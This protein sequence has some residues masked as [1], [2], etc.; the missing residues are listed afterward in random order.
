MPLYT[1]DY[2]RDTRHL[3]PMRHGIYLLLLM[4]CWDQKGPLPLDANECG[5]IANCRSHDEIDALNYV[6]NKYFVKMDDGWYNHRMHDE[7]KK[8]ERESEIY[9]EAGLKSAEI[10]RAKSAKRR[11]DIA[12]RTKVEPRLNLGLTSVGNP[13]PN[14]NPIPNQ[15][16]VVLTSSASTQNSV[17]NQKQ[18]QILS[19][20]VKKTDSPRQRKTLAAISDDVGNTGT[21]GKRGSSRENNTS[22]AP[23]AAV[24]NSYAAA[25]EQRWHALPTRNAHVNGMLARFVTRV[26]AAEAPDIAAFYVGSPKTL[27]VNAKHAVNLLLRDAEQL[28]TEWL[29]GIHGTQTQ[30]RQID[31]TATKGAMWD[32]LIREAKIEEDERERLEASQ[33]L[34]LPDKGN[35]D[36]AN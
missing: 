19:G 25:Y 34:A 23:T 29:T 2:L 10:R 3:T 12:S 18:D 5:G 14:P 24:W 21:A 11:A 16:P 33:Q 9:R 1:G 20:G 28:R 15:E 36:G 35:S 7:I 32:R 13:N 27:Y 30:A 26:P 6:L 8:S 17:V 22:I 4:H 31:E